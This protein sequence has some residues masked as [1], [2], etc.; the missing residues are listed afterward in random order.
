VICFTIPSLD[1]SGLIIYTR[2]A[3]SEDTNNLQTSQQVVQGAA[4]QSS[5][6]PTRVR[7]FNQ[8]IAPHF[9]SGAFQAD[10]M[11]FRR[12][13]KYNKG[14]GYLLNIIDIYSRYAWSFPIKK[15]V[16]KEIAPHI[17]SVLNEVKPSKIYFTFDNGNEFKGE[18]KSQLQN[19][20][21]K[22][23]LN[24]PHSIHSHNT[25]GLIERFNKTLLN[26]IRKYMTAND[27]VKYVDALD[28]LVYNYNHSKHSSIN[29]KP[30]EVLKQGENPIN[31][32][33]VNDISTEGMKVGDFVRYLKKRKQFDKKGFINTYSLNVHRVVGKLGKSFVL[34]NGKTFYPEQLISTKEG[35]DLKEVKKRHKMIQKEQRHEREKRN[36]I[37]SADLENVVEGKRKRKLTKFKDFVT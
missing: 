26:K 27:T 13:S 11:D 6:Q 31:K 32:I 36:E 37:T 30:Y 7:N 8:I 15:K 18:V 3:K 33:D 10:L 9:D 35:D 21:A 17:A 29:R 12:F 2:K 25:M 23:K 5:F 19:K 14:Y 20:G 24:D 34:D 4:S 28:D 16:P 22:I 1:L